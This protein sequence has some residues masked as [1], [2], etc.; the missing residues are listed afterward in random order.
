MWKG[1]RKTR[2]VDSNDRISKK[3]TVVGKEK[4]EEEGYEM[5]KE[6]YEVVEEEEEE[7]EEI[8]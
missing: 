4:E 3:N 7:E 1:K 8:K 5:E 2:E 6:E